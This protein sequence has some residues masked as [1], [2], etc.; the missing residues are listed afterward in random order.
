GDHRHRRRTRS[1]GPGHTGPGKAERRRVEPA[2]RGALRAAWRQGNAR[3]RVRRARA[4]RRC[5]R[6]T[7]LAHEAGAG[8][9]MF[10]A[11]PRESPTMPDTTALR[12]QF[13]A[14]H[15]SGC[16][17]IP[18]PWDLGSMRALEGLGFKALATTSAGFAFSRGLPDAPGALDVDAV[19]DHTH[20]IA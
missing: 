5:Y 18:N 8:G 7:A 16:F 12:E 9:V 2:L 1:G 19:L 10:G 6:S 13:R 20:E 3:P 17:V 11:D 14:L 15:S 4:S